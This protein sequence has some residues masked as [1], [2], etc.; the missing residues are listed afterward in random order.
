MP[1]Y[2]VTITKTEMKSVL[3]EVEDVE[4]EDKACDKALEL[5]KKKTVWELDDTE[6]EVDDINELT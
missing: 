6:Y 5:A 1:D 3:I 2:E 4:D